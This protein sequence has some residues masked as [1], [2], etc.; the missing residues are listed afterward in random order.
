LKNNYFGLNGY[1][2]FVGCPTWNSTFQQHFGIWVYVSIML[3][4]RGILMH[5]F[6]HAVPGCCIRYCIGHWV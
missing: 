3:Q 5:C 6:R 4:A 1:L 2:F